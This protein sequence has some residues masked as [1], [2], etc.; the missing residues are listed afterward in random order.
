[1][2]PKLSTGT[3]TILFLNG[4][5]LRCRTAQN[6]KADSTECLEMLNHCV[7]GASMHKRIAGLKWMSFVKMGI[8]AVSLYLR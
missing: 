4:E 3:P 1:M 2:P 6:D 5:Q 7:I 8:P